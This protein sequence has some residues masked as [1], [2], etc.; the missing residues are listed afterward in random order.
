[1]WAS[2]TGGNGNFVAVASSAG[3]VAIYGYVPPPPW[4]ASK[5]GTPRVA[6]T[7]PAS[8]LGPV[9]QLGAPEANPN[10]ATG[11]NTT[12]FGAPTSLQT[13]QA[14]T[15]GTAALLGTPAGFERFPATSLGAVTAFG[16]PS[17]PSPRTVTAGGWLSFDAGWPF[18]FLTPP[19]V[20]H[21][22]GSVMALQ[23]VVFGT[24]STHAQTSV[25]A[26]VTEEVTFLGTPSLRQ[27][28]SAQSSAAETQFGTP[29]NSISGRSTGTAVSRLGAPTCRRTQLASSAHAATRWGVAST[30]RSDTY[31][32]LGLLSGARF[33][34][35]TAARLNAFLATGISSAAQFG[36]PIGSFRY[37]ALHLAPGFRSGKPLVI[38]TPAC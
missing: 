11:F 7:Q 24:P 17:F 16:S 15:L 38:R 33:G 3:A 2:I 14:A 12:V 19:I 8:S 13:V 1:V 37:R 30:L 34:R 18:V 4:P 23:P 32:A 26:V 6:L 10:N 31:L 35:P 21:V 27:G 5:L 29:G 22:S 9:A 36:D 20:T 25:Q 28:Y